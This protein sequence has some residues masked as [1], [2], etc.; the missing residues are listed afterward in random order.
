MSRL[1]RVA[2]YFYHTSQ[3]PFCVHSTILRPIFD[4]PFLKEIVIFCS[5]ICLAER[6]KRKRSVDGGKPIGGIYKLIS[7]RQH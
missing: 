3:K 1:L 6:V 4:S 7:C 2:R 5:D